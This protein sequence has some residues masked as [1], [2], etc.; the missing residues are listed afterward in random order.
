MRYKVLIPAAGKGARAGLDFPKTLFPIAGIPIIVIILRRV[1]WLDEQPVV[2]V[3]PEGKQQIKETLSRYEL[4][5][6]LICQKIPKG[7]GD[8][9]LHFE[10]SVFF[11]DCES[12]LLIWGDM[13]S[14]R[15]RT[16][17]KLINL[18]E[19][20]GVDFAF[21]SVLKRK[22]YIYIERNKQG[23]VIDVKERREGDIVPDFGETD[24]GVFLFNKQKIFSV[25]KN[26]KE[27]L[28]GK[29]TQEINFLPV[30]SELVKAGF[31]VEGYRI[32]TE[33]ETV[34]FNT[35]NDIK[36]ARELNSSS[37]SQTNKEDI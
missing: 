35:L 11:Q 20:R 36:K 33:A 31:E 14:V 21:P 27:S 22:P 2:I 7:M 23:K 8:A 1:Q 24:T 13:F 12:L 16:L 29:I 17:R 10:K 15:E 5:A 4:S 18:Y 34:G 3:S 26:N 25:M 19:E 9:V 32:A 37:N 28:R 6:E 30:I